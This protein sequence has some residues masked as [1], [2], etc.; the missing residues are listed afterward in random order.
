MT[1]SQ[2][3]IE[4]ISKNLSKLGTKS[5]IVWGIDKILKY[6][7]LLNEV[8]T[9]WVKQTISVVEWEKKNTLREDSEERKVEP[10]KLLECS[11]QKVIWGQIALA[12]IMK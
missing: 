1:F 12:N 2:D 9:T 3:Q 5:G 10:K 7:E 6:M 8:D 11:N 4:K